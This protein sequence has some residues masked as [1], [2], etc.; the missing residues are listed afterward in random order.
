MVDFPTPKQLDDQIKARQNV[1]FDDAI[2]AIHETLLEEHL[3]RTKTGQG[4][5]LYIDIE[6]LTVMDLVSKRLDQYGWTMDYERWSGDQRNCNHDKIK[7]TLKGS[8]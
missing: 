7:V 8:V 6:Y 5:T 4:Y 3:K 2:K 1:L